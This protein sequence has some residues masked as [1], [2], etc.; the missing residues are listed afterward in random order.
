MVT[1]PLKM[2]VDGFTRIVPRSI[3]E[4]SGVGSGEISIVT[5]EKSTKIEPEPLTV[6]VPPGGTVA[7]LKLRIGAA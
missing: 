5:V 2:P 7:G 4:G 1:V 6:N 3:L